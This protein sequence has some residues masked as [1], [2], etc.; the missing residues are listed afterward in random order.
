MLASHD[1]SLLEEARRL[2]D[3]ADRNC[4]HPRMTRAE[5][6]L[7]LV[8]LL[9]THRYPVA[10]QQ[11]AQ[12]LAISLRTLYRDIATLQAQGADIRGA[13]GL[14]Y[15]LHPGFAL[16]PLMFTEHELEA[17][18]LGMR[19]VARRA[20]PA[21]SQAAHD[22]LAKAE[23]VLPPGGAERLN[24]TALFA[25]GAGPS[26]HP[27]FDTHVL[28]DAIRRERKVR[29]SYRSAAPAYRCVSSGPWASATS[30]RR[31]SW[32]PGASPG[33]TSGISGWIAFRR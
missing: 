20:D 27:A 24:R 10:G 17:L 7:A 8:R 16:P 1:I 9:R 11:L 2:F 21:L 12:S 33:R 18:M 6:L 22:V 15:V 32:R 26:A 19:W 31:T 25:V 28:R 5:R 3:T 13:P 14:G 30:T 23:A 4:Q 29:L